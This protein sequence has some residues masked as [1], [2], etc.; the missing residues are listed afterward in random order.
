MKILF[1]DFG[2]YQ[3]TVQALKF[4]SSKVMKLDFI[5]QPFSMLLPDL[6]DCSTCNKARLVATFNYLFCCISLIAHNSCH[7]KGVGCLINMTLS[8]ISLL[9]ISHLHYLYLVR[10][11]QRP[12]FWN[13]VLSLLDKFPF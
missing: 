12:P 5:H 2:R 1:L 9:K 3:I 13:Q 7:N 4:K 8:P 10:K 11:L 6:H